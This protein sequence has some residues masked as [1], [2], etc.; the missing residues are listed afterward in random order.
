MPMSRLECME[1]MRDRD[2][3]EVLALSSSSGQGMTSDTARGRDPGTERSPGG[4]ER[5]ARR[6]CGGRNGGK[7]GSRTSIGE[8]G[9]IRAPG[10]NGVRNPEPAVSLLAVCTLD[11]QCLP[12]GEMRIYERV[13]MGQTSRV[14]RIDT[15]SGW[16]P[17]SGSTLYNS[18]LTSNQSENT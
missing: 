1:G 7:K 15:V 2:S 6:C 11:Q 17:G 3:N 5:L 9:G 12:A 16:N 10:P 13:R 8:S 4:R 18:L 14:D